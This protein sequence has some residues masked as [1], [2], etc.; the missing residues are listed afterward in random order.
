M[1][2]SE[3]V[4]IIV[5]LLTIAT[6][7]GSVAF[8]HGRGEEW[9]RSADAKFADMKADTRRQLQ[10]LREELSDDGENGL[11]RQRQLR[12]LKE[13][14]DHEHDIINARLGSLGERVHKVNETVIIHGAAIA[15]LKE[16]A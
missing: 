10:E 5:G 4:Q 9:R 11:V 16:G 15:S 12:M 14:A 6:V 1:S 8:L 2:A 3:I 7:I 13:Q